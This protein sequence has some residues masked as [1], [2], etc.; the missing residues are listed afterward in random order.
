MIKVYGEHHND[1]R[2]V[3]EIAEDLAKYKPD[4][5]YHEFLIVYNSNLMEDK[6]CIYI[7]PKDIKSLMEGINI[8]PK[9]KASNT[10]TPT[11][12]FPIEIGELCVK[13]KIV[14]AS[15]DLPFGYLNKLKNSPA[16]E[17][18]TRET[19]MTN[20]LIEELDTL[21]SKKIAIVVGAAHLRS[22]PSIT[23][24]GHSPLRLYLNSRD[25]VIYANPNIIKSVDKDI[26]RLNKQTTTR[27]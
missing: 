1:I 27:A 11:I 17:H 25:D 20:V 8:D 10:Y 4:I 13:N 21:D 14:L 15:I 19:Y 6:K 9:Y 7:E 5:I 3:R 16:L 22:E 26:I 2:V 23:S 12:A 24:G 18:Q